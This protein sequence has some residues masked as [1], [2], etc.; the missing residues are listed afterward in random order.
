MDGEYQFQ[1]GTTF[2]I[3][4]KCDKAYESNTESHCGDCSGRNQ[5]REELDKLIKT[6]RDLDHRVWALEQTLLELYY[7]PGMPGYEKAQTHFSKLSFE[8]EPEPEHGQDSGAPGI[9][10][11][12]HILDNEARSSS[13]GGEVPP[14]FAPVAG[15]PPHLSD[16]RRRASV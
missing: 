9:R 5:L 13:H 1:D 2:K 12:L 15:D 16:Q 11:A 3:C 4:R 6:N 14:Q 8:P 7:A 10:C